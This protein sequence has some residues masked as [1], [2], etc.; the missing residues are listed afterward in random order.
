MKKLTI[1]FAVGTLAL[2]VVMWGVFQLGRGFVE[3]NTGTLLVLVML[4]AV[5]AAIIAGLATIAIRSTLGVSSGVASSIETAVRAK[6]GNLVKGVLLVVTNVT[7][8][9]TYLPRAFLFNEGRTERNFADGYRVENISNIDPG[10]LDAINPGGSSTAQIAT[11]ISTLAKDFGTTRVGDMLFVE[12]RVEAKDAALYN[13]VPE[14]QDESTRI[15]KKLRR[16][17]PNVKGIALVVTDFPDT[18]IYEPQFF[19]FDTDSERPLEEENIHG[20]IRGFD[21]MP[22]EIVEALLGDRVPSRTKVAG[23]ASYA[24]VQLLK[25]E[26]DADAAERYG[27]PSEEVPVGEMIAKRMRSTFPGKQQGLLVRITNQP[28]NVVYPDVVL[29]YPGEDEIACLENA[30]EDEVKDEDIDDQSSDFDDVMLGRSSTRGVTIIG[31]VDYHGTS[32]IEVQIDADSADDL[33]FEGEELETAEVIERRVRKQHGVQIAGVWVS[34]VGQ[35]DDKDF[36]DLVFPFADDDQLADLAEESE[37]FYNTCELDDTYTAIEE[38]LLGSGYQSNVVSVTVD[39]FEGGPDV[40]KVTITAADAEDTFDIQPEEVEDSDVVLRRLQEK[41]DD[42]VKGIVIVVVDPSL[43]KNFEDEVCVLDDDTGSSDIENPERDYTT[44]DVSDLDEDILAFLKGEASD[45]DLE[46]AGPVDYGGCGIQ[47]VEIRIKGNVADNYSL[48]CED[49]EPEV[50]FERK[51]KAKFGADVQGVAVNVVHPQGED[52]YLTWTF[53]TAS[54]DEKDLLRGADS[55]LNRNDWADIDLDLAA[56][57]VGD[58]SDPEVTVKDTDQFK[59]RVKMV[60]VEVE[61]DKAS[62]YCI[63]AE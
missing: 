53:E 57:V 23:T 43:E 28:D 29:A 55:D 9:E 32:L 51:L 18:V 59:K 27:L 6:Y 30:N 2:I 1:F 37:R 38:Y 26:M 52:S 20:Q 48:T 11:T 7:D 3:I 17:H 50:V 8:D 21:D 39:M 35:P 13:I 5:V 54:D 60:M 33:G 41:Y 63:D 47:L 44:L 40:L 49:A 4:F 22:G 56:V 45:E 36:P 19:A 15:A 42:N 12:V 24:G 16:K 58:V 31:P 25:I 62:Y 34:V 14:Y 10:I 61:A 46:I